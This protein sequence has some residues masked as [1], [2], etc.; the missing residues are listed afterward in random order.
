M[1]LNLETE[2]KSIFVRKLLKVIP[3]IPVAVW[4]ELEL[5]LNFRIIYILLLFNHTFPMAPLLAVFV[6]GEQCP[7]FVVFTS[8]E[9][10][11]FSHPQAQASENRQND[12][13]TH[14]LLQHPELNFTFHI[15]LINS[16]AITILC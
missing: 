7:S 10:L 11:F 1:V 5:G 9:S 8:L 16:W 6:G 3:D 2:A 15:N 12:N 4:T 13:H 14:Y